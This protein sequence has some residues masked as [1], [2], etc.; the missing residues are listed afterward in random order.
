VPVAGDQPDALIIVPLDPALG[1]FGVGASVDRLRAE[2]AE[3]S[4]K[5]V[6]AAEKLGATLRG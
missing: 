1:L 5:I 6:A 2:I 3:V 4:K